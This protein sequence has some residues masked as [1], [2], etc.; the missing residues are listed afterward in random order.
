MKKLIFAICSL[1]AL[2]LSVA[3]TTA[4]VPE[5]QTEF[6]YDVGT[7]GIV[8]E[9]KTQDDANFAFDMVFVLPETCYS[10][11][12]PKEHGVTRI[13]E[14]ENYRKLQEYKRTFENR[15]C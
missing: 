15:K 6:Y 4:S 13:N 14:Y 8:I 12:F 1:F 9:I 3:T 10:L 2:T 5:S 11:M 7:T